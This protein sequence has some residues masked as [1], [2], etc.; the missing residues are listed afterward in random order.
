MP[1]Y[2]W[3]H[4]SWNLLERNC[5]LNL[6]EFRKARKFSV[7]ISRCCK[8]T[9]H[10]HL[11]VKIRKLREKNPFSVQ[12]TEAG[13]MSEMFCKPDPYVLL[14]LPVSIS[15]IGR[16]CLFFPQISFPLP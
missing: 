14:C 15:F 11:Y 10:Y 6:L 9:P 2:F 8:T 16:L 13:E 12:L 1:Q 3:R 7:F 4:Y 5:L